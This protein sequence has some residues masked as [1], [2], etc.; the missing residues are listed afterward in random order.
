MEAVSEYTIVAGQMDNPEY[1]DMTRK[2]KSEVYHNM[3]CAYMR[4][5]NFGAAAINYKKAYDCGKN[6]ES[7]KC[8]LWTLK[9]RGNDSE[10]FAAVEEYHLEQSYIDEIMQVYTQ[11]E[12]SMVM[13]Q[14]PDD[15]ETKK[16]VKRLKEAY[17]S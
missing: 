15:D 6:P 5:M 14:R 9:L 12:R 4:L 2:F 10:F 3:A 17:R 8:Y 1:K 11:A 13:G 7:L 16:V